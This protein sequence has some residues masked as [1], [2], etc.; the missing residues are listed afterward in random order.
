MTGQQSH[1]VEIQIRDGL[2]YF[3]IPVL[4]C[5]DQGTVKKNELIGLT[6]PEGKF[7]TL[8]IGSKVRQS[9][10]WINSWELM[11]DPL[12]GCWDRDY[13]EEWT[14][15]TTK[16]APSDTTA[17]A[18]LCHLTPN[19]STNLGPSIQMCESTGPF[20]VTPPYNGDELFCFYFYH[21]Q[22]IIDHHLICIH[23]KLVCGEDFYIVNYYFVSCK[24][25]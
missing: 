5:R 24:S 11:S 22:D 15:G 2:S 14:F 19:S 16:P 13:W 21:F 10:C 9:W 17:P 7:M 23:W 3:S 20:S 4:S 12:A 18:R 1:L 25:I 6:V 8:M